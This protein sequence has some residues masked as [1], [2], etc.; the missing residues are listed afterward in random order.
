MLFTGKNQISGYPIQ[1]SIY[2][3]PTRID[4]VDFSH[5]GRA[6]LKEI[7]YLKIGNDTIFPVYD[8]TATTG[9]GLVAAYIFYYATSFQLWND[10][11]RSGCY[12][13]TLQVP[14]GYP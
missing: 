14:A 11:P 8:V 4:F 12:V 5:W 13:H 1:N 6:E 2:A 10:S 3:N 9:G 7:D